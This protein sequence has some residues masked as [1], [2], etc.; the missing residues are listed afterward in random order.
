MKCAWDL[1]RQVTKSASTFEYPDNQREQKRGQKA[2]PEREEE[3]KVFSF[4]ANITRKLAYKV[5][6]S[7][8]RQKQTDRDK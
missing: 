5:Q 1:P 6:L 2:C 7:T 3:R 8:K 4:N